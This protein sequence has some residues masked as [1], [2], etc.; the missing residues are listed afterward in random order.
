VHDWPPEQQAF[1]SSVEKWGRR[2]YQ[3]FD[4]LPGGDFKGG[5]DLP[6]VRARKIS[7][8]R[9]MIAVAC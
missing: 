8:W 1:T 6:S 4:A 9:L 3:G 5:L 2:Q 7:A